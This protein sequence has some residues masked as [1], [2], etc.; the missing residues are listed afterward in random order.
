[1]PRRNFIPKQIKSGVYT[2]L[3]SFGDAP[4]GEQ[5]SLRN[6]FEANKS[7][8]FSAALILIELETADSCKNQ[9]GIPQSA[10]WDSSNHKIAVTPRG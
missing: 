2:K 6:R 10:A 4:F 1:M 3:N 5:I 9:S 7:I 8:S